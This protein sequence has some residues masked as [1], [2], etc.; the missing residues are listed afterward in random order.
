MQLDNQLHS[1]NKVFLGVII[2]LTSVRYQ[3]AVGLGAD[4]VVVVAAVVV[5]VVNVLV[6]VPTQLAHERLVSQG[7]WEVEQLD[8]VIVER[9]ELPLEVAIGMVVADTV[10]ADDIVAVDSVEGGGVVVLVTVF[11]VTVASA[12]IFE[13]NS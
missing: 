10:F 8:V 6:S 13:T 12:V 5:L 1:K 11:E 2:W 9:H 4:V 3:V 7:C